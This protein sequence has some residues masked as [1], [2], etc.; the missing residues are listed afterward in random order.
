MKKPKFFRDWTT[1]KLK[2]ELEILEEEKRQDTNF[3]YKD[4][5]NLQ[6]V[7]QE[8]EDRDIDKQFYLKNLL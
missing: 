2:K 5:I 8:L 4:F 3:T 7:K 6:G 1:N